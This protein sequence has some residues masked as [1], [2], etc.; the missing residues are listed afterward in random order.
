MHA[1]ASNPLDEASQASTPSSQLDELRADTPKNG[2]N[3]GL[4][5]MG[6]GVTSM[7]GN[8]ITPGPGSNGAFTMQNK[9]SMT[10]YSFPPTPNTIGSPGASLMS[11]GF[12]DDFESAN[13]GTWSKTHVSTNQYRKII[14]FKV[15]IL[16]QF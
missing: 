14:I 4:G 13:S 16:L 7:S 6:P 3:V 2:S 9:P 10:M 12:Y 5:G 8:P 1:N 15:L 11:T